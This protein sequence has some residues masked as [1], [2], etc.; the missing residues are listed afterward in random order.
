M[1]LFGTF[2]FDL[3]WIYQMFWQRGAIRRCDENLG[4]QSQPELS[5]TPACDGDHRSFPDRRPRFLLRTM[6]AKLVTNRV[7][8]LQNKRQSVRRLAQRLI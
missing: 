6:G 7:T 5:L 8:N 1:N 4:L 3:G 2:S